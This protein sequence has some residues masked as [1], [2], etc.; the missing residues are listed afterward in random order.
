MPASSNAAGPFVVSGNGTPLVWNVN[1]V[2]FNPDLGTLGNRTNA[3]AVADVTA[4][5]AVWEAVTTSTISFTNAGALPEDVTTVNV[6]DYYAVCGDGLSPIIFDVDG[7]ITEA[8]FGTGTNNTI[9][10]FATPD[11]QDF[12]T[13]TITEATAI[14]NGRFIDGSSAG[15][16]PEISLTAFN[17]VVRHELGHYFNLDHSQVNRTEATDGNA[18]NDNAIATMYPILVSATEQSTLHLDDMVAVSTL[19]PEPTFA[20]GFGKITGSILLP[21]GEGAFQGAWVTARK[22]G[23][24]RLTSV[25][26]ASGA[27]FFPDN[28]G[29][30]PSPALRALYEIP[31]L[32]AGSYTVEIEAIAPGFTGTT[33][34]GPLDPPVT[35][36]GPAEFWN[37]ANESNSNPPD[38]PTASTQI[39]VVAGGTVSGTN[40]ITNGTPNR[41]RQ[42]FLHDADERPAVDRD[43]QHHRC[44]VRH[45]RPGRPRNL[46]ARSESELQQRVVPVH[47]GSSRQRRDFDG[48]QHLRHGAQPS[49][50]G[51]AD[52][53]RR[54]PA[55]MIRSDRPR[56][57]SSRRAKGSRT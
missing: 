51:A 39:P 34:V 56:G 22:V 4:D 30:A 48:E 46:S 41:S 7:T 23:D 21:N 14:L 11:C 40:I 29:G 43:S 50:P 44:D 18:A 12:A 52:R 53:S 17:A 55:T 45:L 13:A 33:T 36:P 6:D 28:P 49:T 35:L 16:N 54:S 5:F 32:P 42:R 8:I 37:G 47:S 1:P 10:A 26:V 24:P 2:P 19:Y 31:G 3:Q 27:R 25:G 20:S 15:Q 57:F 9:V 38:V